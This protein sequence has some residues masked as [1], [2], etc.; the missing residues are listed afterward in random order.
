MMALTNAC[1]A[2]QNFSILSVGKLLPTNRFISGLATE[3]C[4]LHVQVSRLTSKLTTKSFTTGPLV[5]GRN[6]LRC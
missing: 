3:A 2:T 5:Q 1:T 4:L 6:R